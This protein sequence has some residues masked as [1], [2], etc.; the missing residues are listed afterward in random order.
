MGSYVLSVSPV[1]GFT[2]AMGMA[3]LPG[4][5]LASTFARDRARRNA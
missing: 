4:S 3:D 1:A 2:V 5:G